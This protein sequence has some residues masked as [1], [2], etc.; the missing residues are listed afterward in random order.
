MSMKFVILTKLYLY[1]HMSYKRSK[2]VY[3]YFWDTMHTVYKDEIGRTYDITI[4][5]S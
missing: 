3:V 4:L 2:C 1:L 5:I